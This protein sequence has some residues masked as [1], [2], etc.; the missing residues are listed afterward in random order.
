MQIYERA[1]ARDALRPP[2]EAN[3]QRRHSLPFAGAATNG[4]ADGRLIGRLSCF[5]FTWPAL[6]R[7][8]MRGRRSGHFVFALREFHLAAR[9]RRTKASASGRRRKSNEALRSLRP[10]GWLANSMK[11]GFIKAPRKQLGRQ[12]RTRFVESPPTSWPFDAADVPEVRPNSTRANSSNNKSA[13]SSVI[14]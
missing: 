7:N 6:A 14:R 10:T 8:D 3:S 9:R 13:T 4:A 1:R 11:A 2:G 12:R 5:S